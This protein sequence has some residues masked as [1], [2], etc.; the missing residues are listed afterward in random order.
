MKIKF[1]FFLIFIKNCVNTLGIGIFQGRNIFISINIIQLRL[2]N[3]TRLPQGRRK[4]ENTAR[5]CFNSLGKR[6]I[7]PV[8]FTYF[9]FQKTISNCNPIS[10]FNIFI[11]L[12]RIPYLV[13]FIS[14]FILF[15]F[16]SV[17][18]PKNFFPWLNH[19][20]PFTCN[21]LYIFIIIFQVI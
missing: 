15:Y 12:G 5:C 4:K 20:E 6:W 17:N 16:S 10:D 2:G 14:S 18:H 19:M 13:K 7:H 9:E 1:Q 21:F 8:K 11:G 3:F